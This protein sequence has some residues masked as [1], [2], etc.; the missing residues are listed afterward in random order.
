M[1]S[2]DKEV[3][4]PSKRIDSDGN[5]RDMQSPYEVG[6]YYCTIGLPIHENPYPQSDEFNH[7]RFLDGYRDRRGVAE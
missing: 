5:E 3:T 4:L 1:I 7:R 2:D 6:G